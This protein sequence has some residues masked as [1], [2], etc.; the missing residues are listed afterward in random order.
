MTHVGSR[1]AW[2]FATYVL[3]LAVVVTAT[4]FLLRRQHDDG[5]VVNLSGRQ[6]MLTQRMTH[7][8]MTYAARADAGADAADARQRV[9]TTMR[10]FETTLDALASGGPAPIDLQLASFRDCPPASR[11]VARRLEVVRHLYASY[12]HAAQSILEGTPEA[13]RAG[14]ETITTL[15]TELLGEMDTA[16]TLLQREAEAKVSELFVIQGVALLASLVLTLLLVRW[17]RSGVTAPLEKLREAAEEMSLGNLHKTVPVAGAAELRSLAESIER[18]RT[19]LRTLL[20]DRAP[21][22]ERDSVAVEM[23]D[24]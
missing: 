10:V 21:E 4:V 14:I 1:L 17:V 22:R 6:R 2:S 20:E 19:S 24:W 8:L 18:M 16:V 15:E 11:T 3:L 7:Q 23:S 12:R 9:R 13:R 5:L